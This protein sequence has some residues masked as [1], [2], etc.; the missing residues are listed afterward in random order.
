MRL[1][2]DME[3]VA[4]Q[5][6]G[7]VRVWESDALDS[8]NWEVGQGFLN[9]W[10]WALNGG[11]IQRSNGWREGRGEGGLV[12]R[13]QEELKKILDNQR[14]GVGLIRIPQLKRCG[15][16]AHTNRNLCRRRT[17]LGCHNMLRCH[18]L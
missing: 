16:S 11:M 2:S 3:D 4:G 18:G 13:C 12:V 5:N 14:S 7:G 8:E 10:W 17:S 15:C 9:V 6:G 1:V